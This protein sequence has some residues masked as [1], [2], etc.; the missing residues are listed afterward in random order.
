M[1]HLQAYNLARNLMNEHGLREWS[2]KFDRAKRRAGCCKHSRKTIT[3][4]PHYVERNDYEE[5]KD[6]ILHEIAHALVGH[7]H[8]HN[9]VWRAKAREIGAKP[10]R[11][12]QANEI[13][14]PKGKYSQVSKKIAV[15]ERTIH[16]ESSS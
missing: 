10:Q 3:L 1:D 12:T 13:N 15:Q 11:C 7:K 16:A 8:H 4:S 9:W 6:T 5:V 14:L 2:F